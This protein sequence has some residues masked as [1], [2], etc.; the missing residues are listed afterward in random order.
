HDSLPIVTRTA[1]RLSSD[2][3]AARARYQ[4]ITG[5]VTDRT[6]P[7]EAVVPTTLPQ[8]AELPPTLSELQRGT[9]D[10]TYALATHLSIGLSYWREHYRVNDFT[11]DADANPDLARG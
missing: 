6:L 9:A 10:L 4:Y 2:F 8:P 11:L 3:N 7:E 5:P 1:R